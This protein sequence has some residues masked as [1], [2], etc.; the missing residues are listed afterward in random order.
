[1]TDE[2]KRQLSRFADYRLAGIGLWATTGQDILQDATLAILTGLQAGRY[3]RHPRKTD[4]ADELA[5]GGYVK[6]VIN[7][8]IDTLASRREHCHVHQPLDGL[9]G[10]TNQEQQTGQ[11]TPASP[12]DDVVFIDLR[13]ELFSRLK[14]RCP[15][16][17]RRPLEGW[18]RVCG[19]AEVIP[20][21]G[22]HRRHRAE[23]RVLAKQ[24]SDELGITLD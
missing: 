12:D 23:L 10:K 4:L 13:N 16:H 3:G 6:G 7:S 22:F 14:S 21:R 1:M 5:F 8:L 20:I 19:W 17:L 9:N 18:E 24:V 15:N 2:T 11:A